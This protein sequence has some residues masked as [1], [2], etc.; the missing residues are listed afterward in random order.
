ME[1]QTNNKIFTRIM[2]MGLMA[3]A[4]AGIAY[5]FVSGNK[6]LFADEGYSPAVVYANAGR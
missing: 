5:L 6:S 1:G 2:V 4:F 3:L